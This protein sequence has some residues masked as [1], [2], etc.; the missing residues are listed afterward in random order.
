MNADVLL[1]A[2]GYIDDRFVVP[3]EKPRRISWR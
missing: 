3:E 2:F 1:D